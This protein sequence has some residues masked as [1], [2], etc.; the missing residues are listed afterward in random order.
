MRILANRWKLISYIVVGIVLVLLAPVLPDYILTLATSIIIFSIYVSS[1][2]LLTGYTGLISLGQAAFWGSAAYIV[3]ILTTHGIVENPYLVALASLL[4]TVVIAALFGPLALRV[5]RLYFLIVT[6]AFGHMLWCVAMYPIQS[7]TH[8][9]NG[10][11]SIPRPDL[12][13]PWSMTSNLNFYYLTLVIAAI[14]F[15]ILYLI[16]RSPFGHALVGI[17]DNEH[18]MVALGYN[19]FLYKYICYIISAI[20]AGVGGILFAYFNTYVGPSE[21]HWLWSGDA[22]MMMFVGGMG[23]LWGPV[24][25]ALVFTALRY[26]ISTYTMYWFGISGVIFVLVVLFFRGGIVGFLIQLQGRFSHRSTKG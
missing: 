11:R 17:R 6:F 15:F 10:I 16:I 20:I 3:A 2:N 8:G 1:A 25:G 14:C 23:T 7:I 5:T 9:F 4:V 12:G 24:A 13:L 18:R 22:L 26:Y 19:T 21:L